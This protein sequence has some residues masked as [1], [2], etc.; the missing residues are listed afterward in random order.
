[1]KIPHLAASAAIALLIA[2]GATAC[3]EA[4]DLNEMV[5]RTDACIRGTVTE[6]HSVKTSMDGDPLPNTR[7]FTVITVEGEDLFTGHQVSHQMGFLG[8]SHEGETQVV[9]TMPAASDYRVGN[10]VIAFTAPVE[11]WGQVDRVLYATYGGIYREVDTRKGP[12]ILGRGKDFAI[13]SNVT[14]TQLRADIAQAL[15]AKAEEVN[16]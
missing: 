5:A 14:L 12:V 1:M 8:G 4:L 16:R 9:S 15:K 6:V 2:G 10:S 13:E 3:I 7:I 11:G